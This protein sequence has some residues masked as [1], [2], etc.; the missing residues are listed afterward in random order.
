MARTGPSGENSCGIGEIPGLAAR[1]EKG[2]GRH[3][4]IGVRV[5]LPVVASMA[6]QPGIAVPTQ[7]LC[8]RKGEDMKNAIAIM[9]A[10]A[11]I[12]S[13]GCAMSPR[14]G[15]MTTDTGFQV[16]VPTF[17]TSVKQGEVKTVTLSL[18]RGKFFKQDVKLELA[19][20]AGLSIDPSTT[21]VK[22]SDTPDVQFRIA[23]AKDAALSEYRVNVTATPATGQ[24]TSVQFIV[25]VVP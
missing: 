10:L 19:T 12:T 4:K 8:S 2:G 17:T 5:P 20:T 9:V 18:H 21:M 1:K 7:G 14:G 6:A 15:G 24:P 11:L 25:R 3:K 23:A 13:F 22:A 16:A